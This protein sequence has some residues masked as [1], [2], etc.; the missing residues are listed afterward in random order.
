MMPSVSLVIAAYNEAESL[1]TVFERSFSVL[2]DCTDDYEVIILD[3]GST[4]GTRGVAEEIRDRYPE[5]VKVLTHEQN[6]GICATF[7]ELYRSAEKEYVFDVPGDGEF[8]PEV[9]REILPL[10]DD[11]DVVIC[12]RVFRNYTIYRRL[13]SFCYRWLPRLLFRVDLYDPGSIKCRKRE[14]IQEIQVQSRSVFAEAER[15]IRAVR[16]GYRITKVDIR[17]ELRMGGKARGASFGNV[18]GAV[19][20]LFRLWWRLVVLRQKP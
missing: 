16:R 9:L 11:Y 1:A 15:M 19:W 20:D 3:D 5:C 12:N 18:F 7:E 6:Q 2:Q 4:D 8:P 17:P 14:V 13:I 10:L